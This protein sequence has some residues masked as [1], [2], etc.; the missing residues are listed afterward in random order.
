MSIQTSQ[1]TPEFLY[2][3]TTL[4]IKTLNY[5]ED[6]YGDIGRSMYVVVDRDRQGGDLPKDVTE[7]HAFR[8][9]SEPQIAQ[10]LSTFVGLNEGI[11]AK[12]HP[13]IPDRILSRIFPRREIK[14]KYSDLIQ[15]LMGGAVELSGITE[16]TPIYLD[17]R[18][19]LQQNNPSHRPTHHLL[20]HNLFRDY[21]PDGSGK[22]FKGDSVDMTE[23][24]RVLGEF[25]GFTVFDR[26]VL[27]RGS[28]NLVPEIGQKLLLAMQIKNV[29]VTIRGKTGYTLYPSGAWSIPIAMNHPDGAFHNQGLYYQLDTETISEQ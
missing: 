11:D 17:V 14:Q 9:I 18:E 4:S 16:G 5:P 3:D 27:E 24:K 25:V 2:S 10:A 26:G 8:K 13:D 28:R 6:F 19:R 7:Q 20:I 23:E 21:R 22:R 29:G 15:E 1:P 12:Y